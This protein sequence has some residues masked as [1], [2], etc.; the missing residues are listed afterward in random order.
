MDLQS[1]RIHDLSP[2][3]KLRAMWVYNSEHQGCLS[4]NPADM[5]T[6]QSPPPVN[7]WIMLQRG[8]EQGYA[9]V[10]HVDIAVDDSRN[11]TVLNKIDATS[12]ISRPKEIGTECGYDA[13]TES[14]QEPKQAVSSS[15]YPAMKRVNQ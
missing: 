15:M 6:V 1:E 5:F 9:P 4:I 13:L 11:S 8:D 10:T 3:I 12:S 2:G 14:S 7:G